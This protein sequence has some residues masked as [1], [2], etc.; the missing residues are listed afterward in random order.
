M[1]RDEITDIRAFLVGGGGGGG[2][3]HDRAKGHWLIDTLIADPM[4]GYPAYKASRTSWGIAVL[5]SIVVEIETK[6]GLVGIATGLGGPPACFLIE[7]HFRRFL[8]GADPRDIN[9]IWDQI[10]RASMPYGRKGVT[11][12]ALSVVDL[13]LW[14]LLGRL[15][16][17]PVYALIGGAT[18]DEID[19]YCT[20]PRPDAYKA[21]GFWGGKV[22]LPHGPGDG[23]GGLKA[24]VEFLASHRHTVGPDFPL[25][26]DCYMSLDVP[27]AVALAEALQ[28]LGIYWIEE[29][30]PPD[31]FAG[32]R[33]LK[34]RCPTVRWTTGEHEYTRYG[35]RG[36]D[37]G[38]RRRRPAA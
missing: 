33:L 25:M 8:I 27:Y 34:E 24:N 17:E 38:P 11:V 26:V 32:H 12:A 7:K 28:P 35:F 37:R 13:A 20:G 19:L 16:D 14:D 23:P 31:D 30:L 10:Y 18:R 4:S 36:A 6:G 29:P 9:R 15:R 21:Q 1:R 5:G 2:D 3:Y 22:P